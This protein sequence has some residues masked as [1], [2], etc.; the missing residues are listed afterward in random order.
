MR[1]CI[2]F[3]LKAVMWQVVLLGDAA[4]SMSPV[5]GQACNCGLE[6]AQVF[7]GVSQCRVSQY[8]TMD[9][10]QLVSAA[11]ARGWPCSSQLGD[12]VVGLQSPG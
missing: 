11:E 1:C 6:D 2:E 7:A 12:H 4:H 10:E 9:A 5:L 3:W 8:R